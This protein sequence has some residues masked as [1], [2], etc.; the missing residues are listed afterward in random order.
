[1]TLS[2]EAQAAIGL[3]KAVASPT[4][5]M[6]AILKADVDLLWFG[7]IGT[8]VRA[9]LETDADAGDRANDAIRITA[10][11]VRAKVIGEGANLGVTQRARIEFG[12]LGGRCNSDAIDNS[13]GVNSSDVEVN[14]KIALAAAM[15]T[16]KLTRPARNTLLAQMTDE[17]A[18][19]VLANNY[20]QTLAL[21]VA[22]K[23]GMA[24]L[25]HQARF[26]T[27]LEGRGL[28]DRK[29]ENLPSP[30]ALAERE[31][32]KA[33][34]TRA[35]LGVLLAYAKIVLFSDIVATDI[36]DDPHFATDL[37]SYFPDRME[38]KYAREIGDHRLRREIITRVLANDLINRGGPSFITR[39]QEGT[40][41]TVR[42]VVRAFAVVRDGFGLP[43]LYKEI[44]ALDNKV[45]GQVQ[46][47][48]YTAVGRLLLA[49]TA[50]DLKNGIGDKPLGTQIASLIDARK[51]LEPKLD[52]LLPA[53]SSEHIQARQHGF[54]KAGAPEKLAHRLALLDAAQLI[55]DIVLVAQT[56]KAD[57]LAAAKAFFAASEAFRIPRVEEAA[58]AISTTDYYDGLALSRAT[59]MI[60]AA[61]RAI[62]VQALTGNRKAADP[63]AAWL[64]A[65]GEQI[66]K[67]R[68][69]LQALT[70]GSELTVSR[71]SVAAGLMADLTTG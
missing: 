56:A 39:L 52:S 6:N 34:L 15:R 29:V 26:M 49:A 51:V 47:D 68:E 12:L 4:E 63:V 30:A 58:R 10:A 38:K 62:A 7:G 32:R 61:R 16:K 31:A 65:G 45:D 60:A 48:L 64:E 46:L 24:D 18:D 25:P 9:T 37:M 17:V 8:Y 11:D 67:V 40:G 13:G 2:P 28:L 14:I 23:A 42:Q 21:S 66:G 27:V 5:I 54:F 33:P 71:L 43:A 55:P 22:Q 19:L 44:D 57:L 1:V 50:W 59:D 41:R 3:A 70:E 36:P 69:R 20:Q 35:E 53:F